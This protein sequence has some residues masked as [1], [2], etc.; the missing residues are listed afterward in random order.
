MYKLCVSDIRFIVRRMC[1]V[2]VLSFSSLTL[3]S[4]VQLNCY[5]KWKQTVPNKLKEKVSVLWVTRTWLS[6]KGLFQFSNIQMWDLFPF[7]TEL[8]PVEGKKEKVNI[9]W[10]EKATASLS[11]RFESSRGRKLYHL[12]PFRRGLQ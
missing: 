9:R 1:L 3:S 12:D 10:A 5:H 7:C 4:I 11:T 2:L 8:Q 6:T